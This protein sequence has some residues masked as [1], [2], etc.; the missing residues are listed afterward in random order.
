MQWPGPCMSFACYG[1]AFDD[2]VFGDRFLAR[3]VSL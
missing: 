1:A 3:G 2:R